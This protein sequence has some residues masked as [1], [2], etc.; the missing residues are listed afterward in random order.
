MMAAFGDGFVFVPASR[1]EKGDGNTATANSS[2]GQELHH[3]SR[4]ANTFDWSFVRTLGRFVAHRPGTF[5]V[6]PQPQRSEL[7]LPAS[8]DQSMRRQ[9]PPGSRSWLRKAT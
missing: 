9:P 1:F 5:T 6:R 7:S 2:S 4:S 8:I 3:C